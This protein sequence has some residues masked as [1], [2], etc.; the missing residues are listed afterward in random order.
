VDNLSIRSGGVA[1]ERRDEALRTSASRALIDVLD[2]ARFF[3]FGAGKAHL[4]IA[5]HAQRLLVQTLG[6]VLWHTPKPRHEA[7]GQ[8]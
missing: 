1:L 8:E 3:P 7:L 4:G 5:L 2:E 6:F